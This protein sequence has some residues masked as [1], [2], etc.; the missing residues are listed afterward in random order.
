MR[1]VIVLDLNVQ[2]DQ[3]A[4]ELLKDI[5]QSDPRIVKGNAYDP[6]QKDFLP[7]SEHKYVRHFIRHIKS[8]GGPNY[9]G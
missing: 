7:E 1:A 5:T 9:G 3:E 6:G 4:V 2:S 8:A